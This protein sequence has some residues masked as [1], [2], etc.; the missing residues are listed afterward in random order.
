MSWNSPEF[1]KYV[2]DPLIEECKEKGYDKPIRK[3]EKREDQELE[4]IKAH[5][6]QISQNEQISMEEFYNLIFG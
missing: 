1:Y 5:D 4:D 6:N 3:L 2:I